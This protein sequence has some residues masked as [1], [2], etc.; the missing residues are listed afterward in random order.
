MLGLIIKYKPTKF[1]FRKLTFSFIIFFVFY[2][3]RTWG[4]N[5]RKTVVSTRTVNYVLHAS[6]KAIL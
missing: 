3:F 2:L 5:F 1:T 4:F 6:V